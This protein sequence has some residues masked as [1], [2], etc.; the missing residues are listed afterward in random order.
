[1][2][3]SEILD[4]FDLVLTPIYILFILLIARAVKKRRIENEEI[5]KF[6]TPALI[7]KL[8]GGISVC[9]VYTNYY[10]GG[11]TTN[12]YND[13][14]LFNKVLFN[15]PAGY[16]YL[17]THS[18]TEIDFSLFNNQIGNLIYIRDDSAYFVVK[19][20]SIFVFFGFRSYVAAT[21]LLSWVSFFGVWKLYRV[22][23]DMFPDLKK[24]L[25]IAVFFMPSVFFWGSGILKDTV[26]FSAIGYFVSSFNKVFIQR[27]SI[28]INLIIIGVVAQIMIIIK[29]Y[30]LLG[31]MPGCILWIVMNYSQNVSGSMKKALIIP[32]FFLFTFG[33]GYLL[34]YLM[35]GSLGQYTSDNLVYKAVETQRDLKSDYYQGNSFD[36]GEYDAT[37]FGILKKAPIAIFTCIFRPALI[38][39]NNI[40]MFVSALENTF[41]L[42]ITLR[43]LIKVRLLGI[44]KYPLRNALLTFSLIFSFFFAFSV[45]FS[46]SNF[47][48][49]VRYKIPII[50]FFVASVYI[51]S[52][53]AKKDK[54]IAPE[55]DKVY[56]AAL[57]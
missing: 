39:A 7:M 29:P 53:Y 38:E 57:V 55:K 8:I 52:Y 22:F 41:I 10:S 19:I 48:S 12:F 14:V 37:L 34:V 26:T 2:R 35:Q 36:I 5:F 25:A 18:V 47:G 6:Y 15:D 3:A 49:L 28:L 21:V 45:G 16:F 42:F 31:M 23:A 11:D 13:A 4:L 43:M 51:I 9:L 40:V 17:M 56:S 24:E 46:T 27:K 33:F 1:M 32:I 44:V 20:T 54:E 30:I 50:P